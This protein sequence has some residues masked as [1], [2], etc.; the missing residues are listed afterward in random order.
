MAD[1]HQ[2]YKDLDFVIGDINKAT[3]IDFVVNLGDFTNSAYNLEYDQF[4][5]S[6]VLLRQPALTAI[7]NH[8]AIGAGP[9]LFKKAFGE[10][11]FWFESVSRRFIFFNSVN[12]E[13]PEEFDP[14]WLLQTVQSSSKPVIIFSHVNLRDPERYSGAT[15]QTFNTII[16]DSKVALILNGHNHIYEVGVDNGTVM[17]QCPRVEG[18]QWLLLEIQGTQLSITHK[19]SGAQVWQTLK[20]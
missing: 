17:L 20:N 13:D 11:N 10:S 5:D 19:N 3:D 15:A 2:N 7:G 4:L 14:N 12:L 6:F 1:S 16:S 9:S 18:P 8:D